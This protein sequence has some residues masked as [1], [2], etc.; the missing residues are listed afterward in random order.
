MSHL[1]DL[2]RSYEKLVLLQHFAHGSRQFCSERLTG[3]DKD[4]GDGEFDS[5]W[6]WVKHIAS[7]YTLECSIRLR[8]LLDVLNGTPDAEKIEKLDEEA[9]AGKVIGTIIEGDFDLTLRETCNK[10]I[11]ARKVIPT[12][13]TDTTDGVIFKYWSGDLDLSGTRGKKNWR[14]LLHVS[15]WAK[16][17]EEFLFEAELAEL[18]LYVGQDWY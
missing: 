3:S 11:H 13:S 7:S 10:I 4:T 16:C 12:W 17:V 9:R 6:S 1:L 8:V 18:T 15:P 2:E 5:Y 14:L